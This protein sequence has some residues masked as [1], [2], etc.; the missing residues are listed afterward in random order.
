MYAMPYVRAYVETNDAEL[1]SLVEE[2]YSHRDLLQSRQ[3]GKQVSTVLQGMDLDSVDSFVEA[4]K[5]C[6][7]ILQISKRVYLKCE[8]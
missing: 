2:T 5:E 1:Q 8:V 4:L 7:E 6:L 3:I